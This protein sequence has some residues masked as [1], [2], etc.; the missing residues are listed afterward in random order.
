[1]KSQSTINKNKFYTCNILFHNMGRK[2][3]SSLKISEH[4]KKNLY[5]DE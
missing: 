2:K 1:M 4:E 5:C 3:Y